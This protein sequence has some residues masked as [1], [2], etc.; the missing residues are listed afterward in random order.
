MAYQFCVILTIL[1]KLASI[2]LFIFL[3]GDI[4]SYEEYNDLFLKCQDIGKY[5]VFT[6]DIV[7]SKKWKIERVRLQD[8]NY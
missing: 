3:W 5:H 7:D 4:M 1:N 6:F 8:R 2:S